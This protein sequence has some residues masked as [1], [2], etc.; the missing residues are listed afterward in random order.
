MA[1]HEHLALEVG[2]GQSPNYIHARPW[3]AR[4][5]GPD[6][7]STVKLNDEKKWKIQ[8]FK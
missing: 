8:N 1:N 3:N 5:E 6:L 4:F 2:C 7:C